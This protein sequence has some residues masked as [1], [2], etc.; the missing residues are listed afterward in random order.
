MAGRKASAPYA[1]KKRLS[2]EAPLHLLGR[3]SPLKPNQ[4]RSHLPNRYK[5]DDCFQNTRVCALS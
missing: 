3:G 4:L 2:A 5:L 1:T